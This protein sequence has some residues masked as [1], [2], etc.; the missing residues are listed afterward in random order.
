MNA[1]FP[2]FPALIDEVPTLAT[3]WLGLFGD[4]DGSIPVDDVEQ[5]RVALSDAP[6]DAEVV[7]YA[8]AEHGFFCDL[9]PS[10]AADAAADAWVRTLAWFERLDGP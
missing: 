1:R 10:Y 7:R 8:E 4:R 6:V 5:L 2:Q 9:R 3:P